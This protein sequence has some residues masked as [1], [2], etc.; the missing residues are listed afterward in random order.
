M[1]NLSKSDSS[2][3]QTLIISYIKCIKYNSN[4]LEDTIIS[5]YIKKLIEYF[6]IQL[7][8]YESFLKDDNTIIK[9]IKQ[10][11]E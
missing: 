5:E 9:K 6:N 7:I 11:F 8:D 1:E 2:L 4:N 10:K 3:Y